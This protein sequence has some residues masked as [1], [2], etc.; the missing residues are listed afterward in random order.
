MLR[1]FQWR[2]FFQV[3]SKDRHQDGMRKDISEE[4]YN[5]IRQGMH[6]LSVALNHPGQYGS[7]VERSTAQ[8]YGPPVDPSFKKVWLDWMPLY[9]IMTN[10]PINRTT[11]MRVHREVTL[12]ITSWVMS[13]ELTSYWRRHKNYSSIINIENPFVAS[14]WYIFVLAIQRKFCLTSYIEVKVDHFNKIN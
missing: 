9:E 2:A 6:G 5:P 11:D 12:P 1:P 13:K 7:V 4:N 14:V 10:G 3:W 8:V